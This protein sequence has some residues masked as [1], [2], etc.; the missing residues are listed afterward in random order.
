LQTGQARKAPLIAGD[1]LTII[2]DYTPVLLQRL[3]PGNRPRIFTPS[4]CPYWGQ[5]GIDRISKNTVK[6]RHGESGD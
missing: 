6:N 1:R 4:R 3:L 5:A 2:T